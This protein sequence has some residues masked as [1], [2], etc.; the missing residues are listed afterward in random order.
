[1]RRRHTERPS[2]PVVVPLMAMALIPLLYM[3]GCAESYRHEIKIQASAERSTLEIARL[4]QRIDEEACDPW[5]LSRDYGTWMQNEGQ[6]AVSLSCALAKI[7][8]TCSCDSSEEIIPI[9]PQ[10]KLRHVED[11]PREGCPAVN[12]IKMYQRQ[13][14]MFAT[15]SDF[16]CYESHID[17]W[18]R[19]HYGQLIAASCILSKKAYNCHCHGN[20]PHKNIYGDL[21]TIRATQS[22]LT[23]RALECMKKEEELFENNIIE[24]N[25]IYAKFHQGKI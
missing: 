25:T 10:N 12:K 13:L 11:Y 23:S 2:A 15:I 8:I 24:E 20:D 1:M 22:K 6:Y 7:N 16:L 5:I 18:S 3:V 17:T 21:L 9:V 4:Q 14:D 19:E